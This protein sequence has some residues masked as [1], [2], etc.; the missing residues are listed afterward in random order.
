V[1][2]IAYIGRLNF[3]AYGV[4]IGVQINDARAIEEIKKILPARA[5]ILSND[6]ETEHNFSLVWAEDASGEDALYREN[7][8]VARR[9]E[10]DRLVGLL[11]TCVRMAIGEFAP[12]HIFVH[13]G[14]VGWKGA[15]LIFPAN[16]YQGKTTLV[17]ELIKKGALY[18][19][20]EYAVIDENGLVHPYPKPLSLR[21]EG[22]FEQTDRNV[23]DLGGVQA[24]EP[25]PIKLVFLT[26]FERDAVW[27]PKILTPG[28][29]LMELLPHA[30]GLRFNPE[31][32][33]KVLNL[34]GERAI[35]ASSKRG[36]V[37][38]FASL[39]LNFTE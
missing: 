24:T 3:E 9:V 4:T 26:E 20:D 25:L 21:R 19:S 5:Q 7:E 31:F 35:I 2:N 37:S 28:Q 34:I 6:D 16:S 12:R 23:E 30:L 1:K 8:E 36:E 29:G 33:F 22:E 38:E 14:A 27:E 18:Y 11:D 10:S 17:A 39:I 32:V 15:A 13:A